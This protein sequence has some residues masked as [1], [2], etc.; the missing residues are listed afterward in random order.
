MLSSSRSSNEK[1]SNANKKKIF[2]IPD[3]KYVTLE[4]CKNDTLHSTLESRSIDSRHVWMYVT[5]DIISTGVT[6][7]I[8]KHT[9]ET[10]STTQKN[11]KRFYVCRLLDDALAQ[12]THTFSSQQTPQS[13][14][15]ISNSLCLWLNLYI[16]V[17][18]ALHSVRTRRLM[19]VYL[20]L[21]SSVIDLLSQN[22]FN[23][24]SCLRWK[25]K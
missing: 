2:S 12:H 18:D 21:K 10:S 15:T 6:L 24:Q 7:T 25:A 19:Y 9:H 3:I 20:P 11:P 1:M 16:Y 22:W 13:E 4:T 17:I 8:L 14:M 23:T 5:I